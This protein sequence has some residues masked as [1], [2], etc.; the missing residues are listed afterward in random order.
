[1]VSFYPCHQGDVV[2]WEKMGCCGGAEYRC[3]W[4]GVVSYFYQGGYGYVKPGGVAVAA[5][6]FQVYCAHFA[7]RRGNFPVV[8]L[9]QPFYCLWCV[10]STG[11]VSGRGFRVYHPHGYSACFSV[12]PGASVGP[13]L[14][15]DRSSLSALASP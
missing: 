4:G 5:F 3:G 12:W 10:C 2:R 9:A 8:P 6:G 15:V 14:S 13:V 7:F 1:M 11:G